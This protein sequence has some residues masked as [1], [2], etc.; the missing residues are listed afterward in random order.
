MYIYIYIYRERE[1]EKERE[2]E[3][4]SRKSMVS[5]QLMMMMMMMHL[6]ISCNE[7]N[8]CL[9][10][11][12]RIIY[13]PRD[14]SWIWNANS[15]YKPWQILNYFSVSACYFQLLWQISAQSE[16]LFLYTVIHNPISSLYTKVDV[17]IKHLRPNDIR[18]I[19][20]IYTYH[21]TA[22]IFFYLHIQKAGRQF[23]FER[24]HREA[25]YFTM[26]FLKSI[27]PW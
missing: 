13:G 11:N 3:R 10:N 21:R 5:A 7:N 25:V 14:W 15:F 26:R 16:R 17:L 18:N 1:R 4:K 12:A 22:S 23:F 6:H 27:Q 8:T 19:L 20:V 9:M 24:N 2:R